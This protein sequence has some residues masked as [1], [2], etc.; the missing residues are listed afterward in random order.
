MWC[1]H[2]GPARREAGS[3]NQPRREGPP[4][5]GTR[6][7]AGFRALLEYILIGTGPAVAR[8][9]ALGGE[10]AG[11]AAETRGGCRFARASSTRSTASAPDTDRRTGSLPPARR[12][13]ST[14]RFADRKAWLLPIVRTAATIYCELVA[15]ECRRHLGA[16]VLATVIRA[17]S[18]CPRAVARQAGAALRHPLAPGAAGLHP[19]RQRAAAARSRPA[20]RR[21]AKRRS[22]VDT[23]DEAAEGQLRSA[24]CG[25]GRARGRR[26]KGWPTSQGRQSGPWTVGAARRPSRRRAATTTMPA[27]SAG[28]PIDAFHPGASS[29][30]GSCRGAL[31]GRLGPVR[32]PA[33]M[34]FFAAAGCPPAPR[35]GGGRRSV[36]GSGVGRAASRVPDA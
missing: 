22:T 35:Q 31:E 8:H 10:R 2:V 28:V 30:A 16:T 34:A 19:S 5:R 3:S 26:T 21:A 14:Q 32:F 24:S 36:A 20:P 7:A 27:P 13:R 4:S 17:T 1:P 18:R 6:F 33:R 15:A 12:A 25:T 23:G 29:P 11:F 9:F